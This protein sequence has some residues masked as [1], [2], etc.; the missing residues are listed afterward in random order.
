MIP[1][2]AAIIESEHEAEFWEQY[3]ELSWLRII[4]PNESR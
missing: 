1:Y 2:F 3:I 4:V